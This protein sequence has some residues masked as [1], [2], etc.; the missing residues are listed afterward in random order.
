MHCG[1]PGDVGGKVAP[2]RNP[3]RPMG[4]RARAARRR[5]RASCFHLP[6]RIAKIAAL[7][8]PAKQDNLQH[9]VAGGGKASGL[10]RA[11]VC[12]L[13][14]FRRRARL[15]R[16]KSATRAD[17]LCRCKR[18]N[19]CQ[20]RPERENAVLSMKNAGAQARS[21]QS[22]TA[23]GDSMD[24][25]IDRGRGD[26]QRQL[27]GKPKGG[28]AAFAPMRIL[29]RCAFTGPACASEV[30][31]LRREFAFDEAGQTAQ[32]FEGGPADFIVLD[33]NVKV[34]F[35]R[36][37]QIGNRHRIELGQGAEQRCSRVHFLHPGADPTRRPDHS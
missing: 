1:V 12:G 37:N 31:A 18:R 3:H 28:D 24:P 36:G 20:V 16:T 34:L 29:V 19:A 26:R 35:K 22:P 11:P 23:A 30:P 32:R 13:C 9:R 4:P 5:R 27:P 21:R 8:P 10:M 6:S 25:E 15:Q 7:S 14:S 2:S 33:C 17:T